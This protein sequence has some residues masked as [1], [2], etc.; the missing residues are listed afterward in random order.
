M[1]GS[2]DARDP[3]RPP[4][5]DL[6]CARHGRA[7]MGLEAEGETIGRLVRCRGE[8]RRRG[9]ARQRF[10]PQLK[11]LGLVLILNAT[12]LMRISPAQA[13]PCMPQDTTAV[14]FHE[15]D[16]LLKIP[17]AYLFNY[18]PQRPMPVLNAV[19]PDLTPMP[20]DTPECRINEKTYDLVLWGSVSAETYPSPEQQL[21]NRLG[22]KGDITSKEGQLTLHKN[23]ITGLSSIY[24]Y[25]SQNIKA[26]QDQRLRLLTC[27]ERSWLASCSTTYGYRG[28]L[29]IN[30]NFSRKH[31]NDWPNIDDHMMT[32]IDGFISK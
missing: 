32:L 10:V 11:L 17:R 9:V 7:L 20:L 24:T 19:L 4:P 30:Y 12:P 14:L 22:T 13:S 18:N 31:L 5:R 28:T 2:G 16:F 8:L 29:T 6:V 1:D 15:D 21:R 23:A 25:V 26:N 27:T 3:D